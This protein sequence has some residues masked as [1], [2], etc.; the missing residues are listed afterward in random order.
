MTQDQNS[1]SGVQVSFSDPRT[2]IAAEHHLWSASAMYRQ[3]GNSILSFLRAAAL[4]WLHPQEM[5][6]KWIK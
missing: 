3:E 1:A 2:Q 5:Q 4:M 6:R